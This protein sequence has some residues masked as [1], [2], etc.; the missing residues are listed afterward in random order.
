MF[1]KKF[2]LLFLLMLMIISLI[3]ACSPVEFDKPVVHKPHEELIKQGKGTD[4]TDQEIEANKD[5][6]IL[7]LFIQIKKELFRGSNRELQGCD[8]FFDLFTTCP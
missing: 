1:Y 8:G 2:L 7:D 6:S 4:V 3:S 5:N